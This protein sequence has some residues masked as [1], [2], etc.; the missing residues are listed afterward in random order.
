MKLAFVYAG[1]G[2]QHCEMGK[3]L[4]EKNSTF[5]KTMDK[6]DQSGEIKRLCFLGSMEELSQTENTQKC[7]VAFALAVNAVLK[8]NH[9]KPK[10]AAGLSLGEYSAL[11]AA[12]VFS[13]ETAMT[14]VTYRGKVMAEAAKGYDSK[15][16]ALL[17]ADR[18]IVE[19]ACLKSRD[20]GIVA[21]AN[22][23]CPDQIVIGGE[24]AAVDKAAS[25]AL[26]KGAKRCIPL[27]VSGAFHTP[28]MK[29]ASL[30]LQEKLKDISC[31]PMAFPI[32]FN[33]TGKELQENET[34]SE[35]LEKQVSSA[36]YFEDIIQRMKELGVDTIVE[37]GPGK[38]LSGF[39][40]KTEPTIKTYAI[41]D[42]S[43]LALTLAELKGVVL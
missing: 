22:Y 40:R 15:M 6:L 25:F 38:V 7:M 9:I 29:S 30:A 10:L 21:V 12:E 19:E 2:S 36:V 28:I 42:A 41:E 17:K 18:K 11:C 35:L 27:T 1:Q 37:I 20:F 13:E 16:V 31:A 14:L 24:S 32:L 8:E 4:Y 33:V 23:N 5:R 39:V 34:V 3:D 26:E 43:T